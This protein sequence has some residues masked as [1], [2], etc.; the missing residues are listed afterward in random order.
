MK[1]DQFCDLSRG[2]RLAGQASAVDLYLENSGRVSWRN[3]SGARI[4]PEIAEISKCHRAEFF[5]NLALEAI[6]RGLA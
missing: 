3:C 6:E 2:H 5:V 1:P 4:R